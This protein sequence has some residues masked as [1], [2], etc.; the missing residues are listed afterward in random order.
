MPEMSREFISFLLAAAC[1]LFCTRTP[2]ADQR[3]PPRRSSIEFSQP[4][5]DT[6]STNLNQLGTKRNSLKELEDDLLRPF[7]AMPKGSLDGVMAPSIRPAQPAP[8]PAQIQ[9]AR[10][11]LKRR[12]DWVFMLPEDMVSGLTAEEIFDLR[13]LDPSRNDKETQSMLERFYERMR[14]KEANGRG[15]RESEEDDFLG[16]RKSDRKRNSSDRN[17][18]SDNKGKPD[19]PESQLTE[20]E[21]SLKRLFGDDSRS[22]GFFASS[23]KPTTFAEVFGFNSE[24]TR[25]RD[26]VAFEARRE[27]FRQLLSLPPAANG[28]LEPEALALPNDSAPRP[29]LTSPLGAASGRSPFEPVFGTATP[30]VSPTSPGASLPELA[31]RSSSTMPNI[32]P[33]PP[34]PEPSKPALP[35]DFGAPRRRF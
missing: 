25:E 15:N 23:G 7:Q 26:K 12:E 27:E 5:S 32:A 24:A 2:A 35:A 3:P 14:E 9:R 28:A 11:L 33:P 22:D 21:K 18:F 10:E 4:R 19:K 13:D 29:V 6:V 20:S 17:D 31:P 16:L 30:N 1:C 34:R 8:S